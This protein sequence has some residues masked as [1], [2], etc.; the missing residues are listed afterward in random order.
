MANITVLKRKF[1]IN[2][3]NA[4][5]LGNAHGESVSTWMIQL[6]ADGSWNGTVKIK[7]RAMGDDA[8][9][10][11]VAPVQVPYLKR[12]LNGSVADDSLVSSDI[13]TTSII[14]VPAS[15]Q[16]IVVDCTAFVAGTMACYAWPVEGAAA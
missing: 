6:V 3:A 13:T 2:A 14:L 7:A 8:A 12:Y 5:Y 11:A 1:T 10:D 4:Y 16:T 9:T 15:G